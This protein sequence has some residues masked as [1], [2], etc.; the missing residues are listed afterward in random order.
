[1]YTQQSMC[2]IWSC[3]STSA[4]DRIALGVQGA[5]TGSWRVVAGRWSLTAVQVGGDAGGMVVTSLAS[6]RRCC[7]RAGHRMPDFLAK[8]QERLAQQRR[9]GTAA[10]KVAENI[11]EDLFTRLAPRRTGR[12]EWGYSHGCWAGQ[13]V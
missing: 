2:P 9:F 3:R 6:Y 5:E 13:R 10:E 4:D 1:V 8:R 7:D 11:L 12:S